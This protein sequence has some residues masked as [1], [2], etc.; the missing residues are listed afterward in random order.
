MNENKILFSFKNQNCFLKFIGETKFFDCPPLNSFINNTISENISDNF[1]FDLTE[2]TYLDSTSLGTIARTA[3]YVI[4][5]G[6][7]KPIIYSTNNDINIIL[8]SM[9]FGDAFTIIEG[10]PEEENFDLITPEKICSKEIADMILTA[11]KTLSDMNEKNF[12][13][14][15]DVIKYMDKSI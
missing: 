14:F 7:L 3:N 15:K 4:E 9:G 1:V 13:S 2:C 6:G 11:H 10:K 5:K 12:E 8:N